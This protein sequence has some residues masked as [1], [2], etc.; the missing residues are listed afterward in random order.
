[1]SKDANGNINVYFK[2]AVAKALLQMASSDSQ[3]TS[4]PFA[5]LFG[6]GENQ[7]AEE[8]TNVL[9]GTIT[10]IDTD[11]ETGLSV[12]LSLNMKAKQVQ[13]AIGSGQVPFVPKIDNEKIVVIFSELSS[14]G[15]PD[16]TDNAMGTALM[17]SFKYRLTISKAV[18]P[19]ISKVV[20]STDEID[21]K[22]QVVDLPDMFLIEVP[23]NYLTKASK[24]S[25]LIIYR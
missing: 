24:V 8:I 23:M 12:Q 20:Y 6:P 25:E 2:L 18:C 4:D 13:D 1:V 21:Y 7:V 19:K 11:E 9:K 3:T 17:S 22:P 14:N 5:G 16:S 15:T 10:K